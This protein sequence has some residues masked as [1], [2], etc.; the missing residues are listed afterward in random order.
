MGKHVHLVLNVHYVLVLQLGHLH[1]VPLGLIYFQYGCYCL[2]F[3][4]FFG[5]VVGIRGLSERNV[6]RWPT[7]DDDGGCELCTVHDVAFSMCCVLCGLCGVLCDDGGD[8]HCATWLVLCAVF[9]VL[10]Y[11]LC[12][13]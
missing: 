9:C 2:N 12:A 11:V 13:S 6:W 10:C 7:A 3:L 4:D 1:R 8:D 5:R